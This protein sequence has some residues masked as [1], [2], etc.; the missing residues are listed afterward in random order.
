MLDFVNTVDS[1]DGTKR[2]KA[3]RAG[4]TDFDRAVYIWFVKER[5]QTGTPISG[6]MMAVQA[7]KLHKQLHIDN[8]GEFTAS[9]GWLNRCKQCHGI[10]RF[11][12]TGEIRSAD[13][14]AAD[15]FT[16]STDLVLDKDLVPK[17]V[18]NAEETALY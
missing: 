17:Q 4:D 12:I 1:N 11:K 3:S 10:S 14:A 6:M 7:Q 16:Y 9:K 2:K 13:F 15:V 8:A 5:Q 18:Y